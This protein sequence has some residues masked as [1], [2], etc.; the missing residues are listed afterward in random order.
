MLASSASTQ[1]NSHFKA[2]V[3]DGNGLVAGRGALL[4][5]GLE[6][7][8][9]V[10]YPTHRA[11]HPTPKSK[12]G[13]GMSRSPAAPPSCQHLIVSL[14]QIYYLNQTRTPKPKSGTG[15]SRLPEAAPSCQRRATSSS[16][17]AQDAPPSSASDSTSETSDCNRVMT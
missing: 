17:D 6:I 14:F 2:K 9:F 3:G 8:C 10:E 4:P 12:S 13:M 11:G 5:A 16:S 1:A 7:L 15:M